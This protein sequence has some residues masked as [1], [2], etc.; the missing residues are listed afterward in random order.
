MRGELALAPTFGSGGQTGA[1]AGMCDSSFLQGPHNCKSQAILGHGICW[2]PGQANVGH[3]HRI[4]LR[5]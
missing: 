5:L 2:P 4:L 1:P 3:S